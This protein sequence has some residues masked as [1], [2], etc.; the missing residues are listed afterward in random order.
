[1]LKGVYCFFAIVCFISFKQAIKSYYY[2]DVYIAGYNKRWL[3]MMYTKQA[4]I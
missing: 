3:V 4:I 1:M 2:N